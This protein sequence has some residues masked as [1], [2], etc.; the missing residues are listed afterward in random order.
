LRPSTLAD[1]TLIEN[2]V[3][4]PVRAAVVSGQVWLSPDT[5]RDALGWELKPQGLCRGET[6]VPLPEG[7]ALIDPEGISLAGLAAALQRPLALDLVERAAYLG[8]AASDRSA[9]L[10]TLE[11]PGFTLPDLDGRP[12]TLSAHRGKK[13]L[14]V[15][16]ASW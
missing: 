15:A 3:V 1:F 10:A 8:V 16:F 7:S 5:V 2:G 12:H 6:C 14:L 9:A 4:A 13:V 11:A